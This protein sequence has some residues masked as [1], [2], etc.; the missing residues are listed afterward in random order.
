MTAPSRARLLGGTSV[1]SIAIAIVAQLRY[2]SGAF[3][4]AAATVF[5]LSVSSFTGVGAMLAYRVPANRVG[6]LLLGAGVMFAVENFCAAYSIAS[7]HAGG[8]WPLTAYAAWLANVLFIPPIVIVAAGVPLVFPDGR[9]PSPRWRWAAWLLVVGTVMAAFRSAFTPGL[10]ADTPV[11]NP[12]AFPAIAPLLPTI[13]AVATLSALPLF[14]AS[15]SAVAIRYRRGSSI[16]RHQIK[17]LLAVAGVAAIAI[18]AAFMVAVVAPDDA[19]GN[20]LLFVGLLGLAALPVAIAVAVLRYRLYEID[21]LV[22]R[23]IGWA[24][25]TGVLVLVFFGLVGAVQA[26]LAPVTNE[27]TLAVAAS[28]LVAFALFQPL[29]RRVQ[30]AVDRRFDRARYDGQKTV[31]AF[32]ERLRGVVN[33]EGVQSDLLATTTGAVR[34]GG[35]SVWLRGDR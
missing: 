33:L 5:I 26:V 10:I 15:F 12:F 7:I 29:R 1:L 34:P 23:T 6:W 24:I 28:T 4:P 8:D 3:D 31:D 32:G 27:N 22:S 20:A 9:L 14:V 13:E 2:P 30:R 11:A 17:W 25:V 21:R 35:A 19:L 18:P 16:E